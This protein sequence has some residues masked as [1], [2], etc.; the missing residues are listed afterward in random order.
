VEV[1]V[2]GRPIFKG[3]I[4]FPNLGIRIKPLGP[5][6]EVYATQSMPDILPSQ[7]AVEKAVP[8]PGR[9][10]P[11]PTIRKPLIEC[12]PSFE[13]EGL[14]PG[15][16]LNIYEE[17][18]E[19]AIAQKVVGEPVSSIE[20]EGGLKKG[21]VLSADQELCGK[22]D[23]SPRSDKEP[24]EDIGCFGASPEHFPKIQLPIK[25]GDECIV[26]E[27]VHE[28]TIRILAD[29]KDIGGG[30]C[31][32]T[33]AFSLDPPLPNAK[34]E[35]VQSFDCHGKEWEV[36]SKPVRSVPDDEVVE[37]DEGTFYSVTMYSP[38]P[39]MVEFYHPSCTPCKVIVPKLKKLAKDYAGRAII[40]TFDATK[41]MVIAAQYV[42]QGS[43]VVFPTFA[44]FNK[45][46]H[47]SNLK[48]TAWDEVKI[49]DT[50]DK[51]IGP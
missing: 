46:Q 14:V 9:Q 4:G 44:F 10:L 27:G 29:G 24:V 36:K 7:S 50:L 21:W 13:V 45:G 38:L 17:K 51:L 28:S 48:I 32:G 25:P 37:L 30:T 5:G 12:A 39:V 49:R 47:L 33:T 40:A 19:Q 35:L 6:D 15:A 23:R 20:I 31:F 26:V 34:I 8:Y 41:S 1:F 22:T 43:M 18:K 11:K 3:P 42:Q 16:R 2:K